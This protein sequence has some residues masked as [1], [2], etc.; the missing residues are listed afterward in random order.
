MSLRAT[1]IDEDSLRHLDALEKWLKE[2]GMDKY[3]R[4]HQAIETV[5][6][7]QKK[8]VANPGQDYVIGGARRLKRVHS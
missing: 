2:L 8:V 6:E 4:I 7:F 3:D 1:R 5:R